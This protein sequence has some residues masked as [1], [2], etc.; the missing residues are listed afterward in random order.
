[1]QYITKYSELQKIRTV[2]FDGAQI[3][4]L[5]ARRDQMWRLIC[6]DVHERINE[7]AGIKFDRPF[8]KPPPLIKAIDRNSRRVRKHR[9]YE[10]KEKR[11]QSAER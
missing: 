6:M 2:Y 3:V 4:F 1:M 5:S 8:Y 10:L 9:L 11:K 7:R